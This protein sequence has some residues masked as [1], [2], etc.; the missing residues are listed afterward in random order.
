MHITKRTNQSLGFLHKNLS[1]AFQPVKE[2]VYL[3]YVHP[4]LEFAA[5]VWNTYHQ[6]DIQAIEMVQRRAVHFITN[7]Y[8]RYNSVTTIISQL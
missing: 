3:T 5:T 6:K 7:T 2:K 4:K 1:A 8:D